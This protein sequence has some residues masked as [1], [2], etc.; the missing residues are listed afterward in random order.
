ME[1]KQETTTRATTETSPLETSPSG[2]TEWTKQEK[3]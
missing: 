1:N 3:N 2:K